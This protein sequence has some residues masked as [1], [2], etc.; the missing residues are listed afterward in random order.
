MIADTSLLMD[1][2]LQWLKDKTSFKP[3]GDWMEITT[4]FLDRHNDCIQFYIKQDDD[5]FLMT[6]D[7]YTVSDLEQSGC[8]LESPKRK[9]LLETTV[10]GFGVELIENRIEVKTA[11]EKFSFGKHRLIQAMLAV[12]DLFY[13]SESTVASLF[14][15]DVVSWFDANDIRYS[16]NVKFSGRSG[17]DY[18]FDFLIPKSKESP[19]RLLQAINNPSKDKA[20]LFIMAWM[21]TKETRSPDAK[22]LVILNDQEKKV[23]SGVL[24]AFHQYDIPTIPWSERS[25][26]LSLIAS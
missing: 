12:N 11:K 23:S 22:A 15:E 7:G 16:Q 25:K 24:T 10:R 26:N 18:R 13:L 5:M 6:D 2:Y 4:P 17:Y 19:E 8:S 9:A 20:Q 21:D 14:H 3:V 1:N